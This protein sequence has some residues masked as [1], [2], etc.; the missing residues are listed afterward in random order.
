MEV[1]D[2]DEGGNEVDEAGVDELRKQVLPDLE[3]AIALDPHFAEAHLERAGSCKN[4][5][6]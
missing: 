3:N 1:G 4:R 5:E 6:R 2:L